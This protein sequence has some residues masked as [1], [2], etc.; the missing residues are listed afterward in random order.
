VDAGRAWDNPSH[1]W[2]LRNQ[3]LRTD[4]GLGLATSEDNVRLYI[5]R[6]LRQARASAIVT[7]RLQRPF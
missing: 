2:D 7:L 4:G 1:S 5:A 3:H 6:D